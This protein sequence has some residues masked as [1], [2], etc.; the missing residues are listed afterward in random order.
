MIPRHSQWEVAKTGSEQ[1]TDTEDVS[2]SETE[3]NSNYDREHCSSDDP[4]TAVVRITGTVQNLGG[5]RAYEVGEVSA[6]IISTEV[7]RL[8]YEV[9]T[10][11]DVGN[12]FST[13]IG[14][15]DEQYRTSGLS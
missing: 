5:G 6:E 3:D 4:I 13:T 10:T 15:S 8:I 2:D 9:N 12:A 11:L 14:Y 1:K 7:V